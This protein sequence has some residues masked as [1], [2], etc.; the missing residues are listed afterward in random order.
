MLLKNGVC[1]YLLDAGCHQHSL[2]KKRCLRRKIMWGMPVHIHMMKGFPQSSR[3][4]LWCCYPAGHMAYEAAAVVPPKVHMMAG[5]F[6]L[7]ADELRG[8]HGDYGTQMY[9]E[10]VE[11]MEVE[12]LHIT[13]IYIHQTRYLH[14]PAQDLW[15]K[16]LLWYSFSFSPLLFQ[17]LVCMI[18]IIVLCFVFICFDFG[19]LKLTVLNLFWHW[20]NFLF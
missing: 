19:V 16:H 11:E 6:R 12:H 1:R 14:G 4:C 7:W 17:S 2:R 10:Y 8:R 5:T 9:V 15:F 18:W 20:R 13:Y 3:R